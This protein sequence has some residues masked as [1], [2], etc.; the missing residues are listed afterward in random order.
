MGS[1]GY[2]HACFAIFVCRVVHYSTNILVQ[3]PVE[4][5]T[6]RVLFVSDV[7][8][9]RK[10]MYQRWFSRCS[11]GVRDNISPYKIHLFLTKSELLRFA[12]GD[13]YSIIFLQAHNYLSVFVKKKKKWHCGVQISAW[14]SYWLFSNDITINGMLLRC[15][16]KARG[17]ITFWIGCIYVVWCLGSCMNIRCRTTCKAQQFGLN[18]AIWTANIRITFENFMLRRLF[19]LKDLMTL[20]KI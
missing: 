15:W 8:T 17:H 6:S 1:Y 19:A 11:F 13:A 14:K 10:F 12:R 18:T 4:W 16:R 7:P 2:V 9:P 5:E 3:I 20:C